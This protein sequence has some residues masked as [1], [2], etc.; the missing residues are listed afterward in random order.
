[1][2]ILLDTNALGARRAVA[3]GP[4]APLADSLSRDLEPLLAHELHFPRD[5]ALLSREGGR[6]AVDGALLEFDPFDRHAHRCPICG[7]T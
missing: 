3:A 1:M 6:C 5:K 2:T 7:R 4:L